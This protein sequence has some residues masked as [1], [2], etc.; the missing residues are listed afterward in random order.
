[1]GAPTGN[2]QRVA[3]AIEEAGVPY[4]PVRIGLRT[5]EHHSDAFRR[6]NPRAQV[7]V[8]VDLHGTHPF[9]LTQSN[10]IMLYLADMT[11]GSLLPPIGTPERAVAYERF[12][13]MLTDVIA[14]YH[15]AN[16]MAA[17][18]HGASADAHRLK[19][20]AAFAH[21]EKFLAGSTNICGNQFT[22]ADVCAVTIAAREERNLDWSKLPNTRRWF[23]ETMRR[24]SV[25]RGMATFNESDKSIG[26]EPQAS[27]AEVSSA[28]R[29]KPQ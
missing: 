13:F 7:P 27:L 19:S 6:I 23:D 28:F 10:A 21:T 14:V 8:L 12:M 4:H 24:P 22:L 17:V 11:P 16:F 15:A 18:E 3:I 5:G 1:M 9:V 26:S 20:M 2:C 29:F 25:I